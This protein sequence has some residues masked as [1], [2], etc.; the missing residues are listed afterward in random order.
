MELPEAVEPPEV[1]RQ[2]WVTSFPVSSEGANPATLRFP[3]AGDNVF[4]LFKPS[5]VKQYS[6]ISR[7]L[8]Q[9]A[10]CL[11]EVINAEIIK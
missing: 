5:N 11:M 6:N 8:I 4:L 10:I 3:E 1:R 7:K 2:A 9:A